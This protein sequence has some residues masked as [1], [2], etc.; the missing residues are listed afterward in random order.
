M[1]EQQFDV[2]EDPEPSGNTLI[3]P[4]REGIVI[5]TGATDETIE[6]IIT[7][8]RAIIPKPA[9]G[10]AER[11]VFSRQQTLFTDIGRVVLKQRGL[12]VP[13]NNGHIEQLYETIAHQNVVSVEINYSRTNAAPSEPEIVSEHYSVDGTE[14]HGYSMTRSLT[15]SDHDNE[16]FYHEDSIV[17]EH[18]AQ[19]LL[20]QI[21]SWYAARQQ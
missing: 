9:D 7:T 3:T 12:F 4:I 11:Y 1:L 15:Y 16:M 8:V 18:D 17:G 21:H 20:A 10:D 14:E 19:A 5:D 2:P 6:S 13:K